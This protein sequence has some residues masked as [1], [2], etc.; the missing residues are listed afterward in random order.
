MGQK[1]K[2]WARS[3]WVYIL[4]AAVCLVL[5]F[6]SGRRTSCGGAPDQV[7][8]KS[9]TDTTATTKAKDDTKTT[10]AVQITQK[11]QR[12]RKTVIHRVDHTLPSGEKVTDTTITRTD[13]DTGSK[14]TGVQTATAEHSTTDETRHTVEDKT[15]VTVYR[16]DWRAGVLLG[17][18]LQN[19][20]ANAGNPLGQVVLGVQAERRLPALPFLPT[21]R[22][23]IG[24]WA[25]TPLPS[26]KPMAGLSIGIEF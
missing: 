5:G 14:T 7:T 13:G 6:A 21:D 19:P 10:S 2:T 17:A 4:V 12:N 22:M 11:V 9:K 3:H 23:W 1:L 25:L 20:L 15:K 16:R 8:E 24:V 18:T 26:F